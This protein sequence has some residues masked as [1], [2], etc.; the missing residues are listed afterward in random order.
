MELLGGAF[1]GELRDLSWTQQGHA[2]GSGNPFTYRPVATEDSANAIT[3]KA[4]VSLFEREPEASDDPD[5]FEFSGISQPTI[6]APKIELSITD[7]FGPVPNENKKNPGAYVHFNIDN[8][9]F[10]VKPGED[11]FTGKPMPDYTE[12]DHV[13]GENDLCSAKIVFPNLNVGVVNSRRDNAQLCVWCP[14]P[15]NNAN[16][17]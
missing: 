8:D 15:A 3:A 2:L 5:L 13:E 11:E 16:P 14:S 9:N 10:N 12:T 7:L 17:W 4:V 1:R 6:L